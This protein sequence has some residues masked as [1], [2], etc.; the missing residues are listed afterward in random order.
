LKGKVKFIPIL[1]SKGKED[2]IPA[3]WRD[4]E[5]IGYLDFS[6]KSRTSTKYLVLH[7][8][9][10]GIPY[11]KASGTG[12]IEFPDFGLTTA[13][14]VYQ[15]VSYGPIYLAPPGGRHDENILKL[16]S[17]KVRSFSPYWRA[18][19]KL[20]QPDSVATLPALVH[21]KS[22]LFHIGNGTNSIKPNVYP[23]VT[24]YHDHDLR[25]SEP[26]RRRLEPAVREQKLPWIRR[27]DHTQI[28]MAF[29]EGQIVCKVDN[30]KFEHTFSEINPTL[31]KRA[32]L[33]A[34]GDHED[35]AET[36]Q[37]DYE[38]EFTEISYEIQ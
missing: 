18:G 3:F 15:G 29:E 6:S 7:N 32:Y 25:A 10:F 37:R 12:H 13:Y 23:L 22:L 17:F 30:G 4:T 2:S 9:I 35:V 24:A 38:V 34:W 11:P 20:E 8:R 1:R 33:V 19:F 26:Q 16:L 27:G 5:N 28:D 21:T 14:G 36:R 31:L